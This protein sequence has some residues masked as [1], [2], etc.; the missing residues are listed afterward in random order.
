MK[1]LRWLLVVPAGYGGCYF[2]ILFAVCGVSLLQELCPLDT[3][4]SGLCFA[5]WYKPL[6][7]TAIA[8]GAAVGAACTVALPVLIAPAR[9]IPVALLAFSGG[10]VF[11]A[12][13]L[14]NTGATFLLPFL[15][16]V[17]SGLVTTFTVYKR[18]KH[19]Q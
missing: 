13:F 19:P 14:V 1:Y 16:A 6:E 17:A 18:N 5:D 10:A 3:Q 11:A 2:G 15:L 9:K 4:V 12:W 8:L 7:A